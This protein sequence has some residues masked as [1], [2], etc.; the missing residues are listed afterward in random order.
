MTQIALPVEVPPQ[1][2][3][4]KKSL[5]K[6][7]E[8]CAELGGFEMDKQLA[9]RI[10]ADTTQISRWKSEQEGIKW[11]KLAALMDACGNDVP[12]LWMVA[13]RGYDLF[14]MRKLETETERENRLLREENAAL[15]RALI[16]RA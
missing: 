3:L 11:P 7:L 2:I 4:R 10:G 14:S 13:Q 9:G 16:A 1:A 8:L 6:A 12:V 5:G 15:R